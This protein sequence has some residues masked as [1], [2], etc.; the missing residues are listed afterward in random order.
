M[1]DVQVQVLFFPYIPLHMFMQGCLTVLELLDA[2]QQ[3]VCMYVYV[4]VQNDN[5]CGKQSSQHLC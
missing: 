3:A 4:N 2:Q 1:Y 5:T